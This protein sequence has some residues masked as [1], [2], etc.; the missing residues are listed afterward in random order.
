VAL[1]C[2]GTAK[3]SHNSFAIELFNPVPF[4]YHNPTMPPIDIGDTVIILGGHNKVLHATVVEKTP[5]MFYLQLLPDQQVIRVMQYNVGVLN[6]QKVIG[7]NIRVK[8]QQHEVIR[9]EIT[10]K[11]LQLRERIDTLMQILKDLNF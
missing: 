8:Q 6:Q 2:T 9:E 7:K 11:I 10:N 3:V 5:E 4:H 1:F